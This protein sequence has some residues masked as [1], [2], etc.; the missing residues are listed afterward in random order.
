M[1][2]V[3]LSNLSF[4]YYEKLNIEYFY[5]FNIKKLL[6]LKI[7]LN[8][9]FI[10]FNDKSIFSTLFF[11]T[12]GIFQKHCEGIENVSNFLFKN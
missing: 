4:F 6:H 7:S 2:I 8:R 12:S 3:F 10:C 5:L 9:F 11:M 1:K